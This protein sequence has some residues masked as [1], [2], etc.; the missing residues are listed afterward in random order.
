MATNQFTTAMPA[1]LYEQG[2]W[3]GKHHPAWKRIL[4]GATM[5]IY[6]P[7][8]RMLGDENKKLIKAHTQAT[9]EANAEDIKANAHMHRM[10]KFL[11]EY[12]YSPQ[13][14]AKEAAGSYATDVLARNSVN[15]ADKAAGETNK[16]F[17]TGRGVNART[18]GE[19]KTGANIATYSA[20]RTEGQNRDLKAQGAQPFKKEAGAA[21]G[22]KDVVLEQEQAT[23]ANNSKRYQETRAL[24]GIPEQTAWGDT[25]RLGYDIDKT[26]QGRKEFNAFTSVAQDSTRNDRLASALAGAQTDATKAELTNEAYNGPEGQRLVNAELA[27]PLTTTVGAG[28]RAF[29]PIPIGGNVIEGQQIPGM[30][31]H[32]KQTFDDIGNPIGSQVTGRGE[33][34]TPQRPGLPAGPQRIL[35]G[36]TNKLPTLR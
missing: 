3:P 25:D 7:D 14:A 34:P 30:M 12:G 28:Q 29:T 6:D 27:H 13:D 24:L 16:E 32:Y 26:R 19:T 35:I 9:A 36:N 22:K 11:E 18:E 23:L 2:G 20:D 21:G 15:M 33:L 1:G 5:G 17:N 4:Q 10:A 8:N 31:P